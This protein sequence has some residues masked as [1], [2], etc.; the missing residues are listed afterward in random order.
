MNAIELLESQHREV[1]DLFESLED[2][3]DADEKD[4]LFMTLADLLSMHA[5]IE[6]RLFYPAVK[7]VETEDLLR[8][9]VEEHLSVKRLLADLLET[10]PADAAFDARIKVLEE[11]VAH[12]VEEEEGALFPE[13]KKLL[14][15]DQLE[16]L[17][18]EMLA[19][20]SEIED[21]GEPRENVRDETI[22]PAP[23]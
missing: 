8:E 12:H 11:Q 18:G 23:I 10:D 4:D 7:A 1:E 21:A 20:A 6:E 13:V 3:K 5:A 17:G 14:D 19:L 15:A 2:S 16:A 9:A 22:E